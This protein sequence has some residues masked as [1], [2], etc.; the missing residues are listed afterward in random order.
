[1]RICSAVSTEYRRVTDRQ[2]D[3][4]TDEQTSCD[5]IVRAMHTR[6]AVK[7]ANR[8]FHKHLLLVA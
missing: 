2:T 8:I 3:G 5:G 4:Q 6:R 1:M 7:I